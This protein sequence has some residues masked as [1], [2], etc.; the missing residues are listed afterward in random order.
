MIMKHIQR[1][2]KWIDVSGPSEVHLIAREYLVSAR[3]INRGSIQRERGHAAT[4]PPHPFKVWL[5]TRT[6]QKAKF[7]WKL[8]FIAPHTTPADDLMRAVEA[9]LALR[10]D[11]MEES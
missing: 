7:I 4:E 1:N 6:D 8:K 3:E 2:I 10:I 5:L 9:M 11:E